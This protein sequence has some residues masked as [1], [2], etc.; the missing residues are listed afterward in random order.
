[1]SV[2]KALADTLGAGRLTSETKRGRGEQL[3][4][5]AMRSAAN[6]R[7]RPG[8]LHPVGGDA[9]PHVHRP[10]C[11]SLVSLALTTQDFLHPTHGSALTSSAPAYRQSETR[12]DAWSRVCGHG[13]VR[14]AR[15][16]SE[17]AC[18]MQCAHSLL[19]P[20]H[21]IGQRERQGPAL[22]ATRGRKGQADVMPNADSKQLYLTARNCRLESASLWRGTTS[23]RPTP[24]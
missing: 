6:D 15:L 5:L 9:R 19:R 18:A 22:G 8:E 16:A 3:A 14:Y 10:L 12:Q 2:T 11:G 17:L 24:S 1:M 4:G 23:R 21:R 7:E 13:F 20:A